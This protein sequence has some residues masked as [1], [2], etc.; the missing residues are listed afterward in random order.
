[1]SKSL[2]ILQ[3][4]TGLWFPEID[5]STLNQADKDLLLEN[6]PI[7]TFYLEDLSPPGPPIN[8]VESNKI[9]SWVDLHPYCKEDHLGV[10]LALTEIINNAIGVTEQLRF[11]TFNVDEQ[12]NL[13]KFNAVVDEAIGVGFYLN[14]D[15]FDVAIATSFHQKV[16][17]NS[18]QSV[19]NACFARYENKAKG[20]YPIRYTYFSESEAFLIKAEIEGHK[21]YYVEDGLIGSQWGGVINGML[22]YI[23]GTNSITPKLSDHPVIEGK[24]IADAIA[25][26][27]EY[28]YQRWSPPV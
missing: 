11:N 27:N 7:I 3:L 14:E 6:S 19:S 28:F 5:S 23:N 22:D 25:E 16:K 24:L 12:E 9:N 21:N 26:L 13:L 1:M 20:W 17:L 4:S 18:I 15:G 8:Y 2:G 10:K